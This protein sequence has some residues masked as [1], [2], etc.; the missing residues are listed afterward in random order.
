[1]GQFNCSIWR[2]N[3]F[4]LQCPEGELNG[5]SKMDTRLN[6]QCS[7]CV[8]YNW[9]PHNF[10]FKVPTYV[11]FVL[12]TI[13]HIRSLD[14]LDDL[15]NVL[16]GMVGSTLLNLGLLCCKHKNLWH[17]AVLQESKIQMWRRGMSKSWILHHS[18]CLQLII[19]RWR[20]IRII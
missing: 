14:F 5:S 10:P 18:L 9:K 2:A 4:P 13:L 1:M 15:L 6:C 11:L 19:S 12:D 3:A 8:C 7:R 17:L 20:S 16:E